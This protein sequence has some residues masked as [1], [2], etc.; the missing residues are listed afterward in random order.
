MLKY[1]K[2]ENLKCKRTFAKKLIVIAPLF[3]VLLA[4]TSGMYFVQNGYNW[5]YVIILPGL[6]S[7]MAALVNQYE[8]KKLH[9]QTV[10]SLPVSLKKY[11]FPKSC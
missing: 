2:A 7:L 10:F 9:Y 5:W 11:G 4:V 1:I 6:I 3:M 8:D